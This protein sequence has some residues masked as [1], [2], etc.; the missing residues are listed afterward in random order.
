[1]PR[2]IA[3][4]AKGRKIEL[5]PGEVR[6]AT[7]R[8]KQSLFDYIQGLIRQASVLD[9]YCGSGALGLES[10]SR[11]ASKALFVDLSHKAVETVEKNSES[12]GFSFQVQCVCQDTFKFLN[13]LEEDDEYDVIF[14][15]PPYKIAQPERLIKALYESSALSRGGVI[16]IEYSRHN[17][18]IADSPFELCRRKLYGETIMDVWEYPE[19]H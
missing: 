7:A 16:C 12:L 1:M 9:L 5:P 19:D 4:T 18:P 2:I 3:G 17:E 8:V 6:P 14:V 11:G 13:Y 15:S 10:L